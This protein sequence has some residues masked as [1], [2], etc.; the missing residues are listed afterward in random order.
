MQNLHSARLSCMQFLHSV[1]PFF[2]NNCAIFAQRKI[3]STSF[4][5]SMYYAETAHY[6]LYIAISP[7]KNQ[8]GSNQRNEN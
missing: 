4:F 8:G 5:V 1:F 3:D 2:G 6:I 7:S